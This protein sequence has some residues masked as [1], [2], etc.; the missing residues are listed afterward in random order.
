MIRVLAAED[1]PLAQRAIRG[2]LAPVPDIEV[3]DIAG[4][5]A[6]ALAL[7]ESL[8]PDVLITDLH[9]PHLNGLELL[10]AVFALPDPPRALCFTA[11]G[12][13]S[14]MRAALSAGASG[15]LLKVDPPA[16]LVQ[17]IRSAYEGDALVSPKLTAQVLRGITTVGARPKHLND[18]D[19]ELLGLVGQGL[20]N[21]D[22]GDALH[23]APSTVKTYVSRLLRKTDSRSRAQLAAR[24]HEWGSWSAEARSRHRRRFVRRGVRRPHE[25]YST[26]ST[27]VAVADPRF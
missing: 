7:V 23:L 27:S 4:D 5:G 17:A 14:S 24:A 21:G 16:L 26:R 15:F 25:T 19:V 1:D 8:H 13:E 22:I 9:M 12:D 18:A 20:N 2:Y 6:K 10:K 3:L 11:L